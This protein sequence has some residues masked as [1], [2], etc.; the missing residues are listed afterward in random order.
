MIQIA[1]LKSVLL[2][3]AIKTTQIYCMHRLSISLLV[4]A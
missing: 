2:A 3:Q 4:S 1:D